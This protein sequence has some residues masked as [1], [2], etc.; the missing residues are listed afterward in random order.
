MKASRN[1]KNFGVV[2]EISLLGSVEVALEGVSLGLAGERQRGLIGVLALEKGKVVST[3]RLLS[4]LWGNSPPLTARTKLQGL[5]SAFRIAITR[6]VSQARGTRQATAMDYLITRPHGYELRAED[7]HVDIEDFDSMLQRARQAQ[8]AGEHQTA[9]ELLAA[10]LR[11]WSGP[12][13][14]DVRL[15]GVRGIA[16]AADERRLLAVEAKAEID[17]MLG[18]PDVVASELPVWVNDYP[19]RERLRS[20]LMQALCECGYRAGALR[21]YRSGRE[22]IVS[23]L[24]LEPGLELR[25]MHQWI[26]AGEPNGS[27]KVDGRERR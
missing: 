7:V 21:V 6:Q 10:G 24:G 9:R 19:L 11:L 2:M 1:S 15:P 16:E 22:A 5:V 20:L 25:A 12:A 17:L 14:S 27:F 3:S 23:E 26:L 13:L 4:V 18:S 8:R